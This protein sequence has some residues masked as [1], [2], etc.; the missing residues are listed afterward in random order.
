MP[1]RLQRFDQSE[2]LVGCYSC[3]DSR[4]FCDRRQRLIR[5]LGDFS[6][7]HGSASAIVLWGSCES[8]LFPKRGGCA[9]VIP[10]HHLD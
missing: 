2:F 10:C 7:S 9:N 8:N 5:L 3:K 6:P 4:M 1:A